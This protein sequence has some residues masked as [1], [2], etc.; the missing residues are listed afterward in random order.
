M[1]NRLSIAQDKTVIQNLTYTD[2]LEEKNRGTEDGNTVL[3]VTKLKTD[4][5][6]S[7]LG[8]LQLAVLSNKNVPFPHIYN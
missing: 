4:F 8:I 7:L 2:M 6:P 1:S 3:T 5:S